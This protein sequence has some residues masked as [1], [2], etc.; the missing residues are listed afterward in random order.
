LNSKG[1]RKVIIKGVEGRVRFRLERYKT[2]CDFFSLSGQFTEGLES[3]ELKKWIKLELPHK[4]YTLVSDS[5]EMLSG[6]VL[7]SA[8]H[9]SEKAKIYAKEVSESTIKKYDN[10]Q[11]CIPFAEPDVAIYDSQNKEILLFDDAIGVKRQKEKRV[12]NYKKALKTVQTDVIEI[13][14][15]KGGFDYIT[16]GCGVKYWDIETALLCWVCFNYGQQKLPIVAITDGARVIRNRIW[17]IFGGQVTIILDWYHL[18]KKMRELLSMISWNKQQKE[19]HLKILM[20]LF[21]EGKTEDCL[22]YLKA[23]KPRNQVKF[24]ELIEYL[25]KHKKEIINYKKRK[26]SGKIIG[27]GRAEKGVDLVVA[28]RQKNK[29]IA[30]SEDGSHALAVL[31]ADDY[32]KKRA[33]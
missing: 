19:E 2:G 33:A 12:K 13:Q 5:L 25:E 27:S 24:D 30:W 31:R 22:T 26:E 28:Q 3:K 6:E 29:P 15:P 18:N 23:I 11:L 7:Y 21:W 4:S 14:K 17:S 10:I 20:P 1:Y 32:N 9:L 16:A 8:N